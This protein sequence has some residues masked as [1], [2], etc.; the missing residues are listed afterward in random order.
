MKMAD[1]G[2]R[3]AYNVQVISATGTPIV[4]DVQPA[5]T[6]SDRGLLR[7]GLERLRR[8]FGRLPERYLADGGFTA[9]DAIE[10]AHSQNIEVYCAPSNSKHGTDPYA[11]RP[12]DGP[13]VRTWRERMASEAGQTIYKERPIRDRKSQ[14]LNSSPTCTT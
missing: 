9:A 4:V 3:P 8:R 13:G 12:A 1:G 5:T 11:P 14:R 7:P 2:F 10:W 6:G